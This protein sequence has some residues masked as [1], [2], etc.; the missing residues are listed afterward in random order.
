MQSI[1]TVAAY[2]EC[3]QSMKTYIRLRSTRSRW[4]WC[5]CFNGLSAYASSMYLQALKNNFRLLCSDERNWL[6]VFPWVDMRDREV[7]MS[8]QL[9]VPNFRSSTMAEIDTAAPFASVRDAV[10]MFGEHVSPAKSPRIFPTVN[11]VN[12]E[13]CLS[14]VT[15]R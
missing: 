11:T 3:R 8:N 7:R 2:S 4:Y 15:W 1:N 5:S 10:N 9:I 12:A 14:L 13:V 6:S